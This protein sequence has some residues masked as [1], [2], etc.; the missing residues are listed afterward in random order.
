VRAVVFSAD[1]K[2]LATYAGGREEVY[3]WDAEAGKLKR[4][5]KGK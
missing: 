3:L 2:T 5:L 1:G 4:T